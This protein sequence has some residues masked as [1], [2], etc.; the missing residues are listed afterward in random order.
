MNFFKRLY[1]ALV[2][3]KHT[4]VAEL[5]SVY[6][7]Y[8][9]NRFTQNKK[10]EY[11]NYPEEE[12]LDEKLWRYNFSCTGYNFALVPIAI[13]TVIDKIYPH[14]NDD[15]RAYVDRHYLYDYK[16]TND[17]TVFF[18]DE[19]VFNNVEKEFERLK[20]NHSK[21]LYTEE[22]AQNNFDILYSKIYNPENTEYIKIIP[23]EDKIDELIMTLIKYYNNSGY[24]LNDKIF[25]QT[26]FI[27]DEN[28]TSFLIFADSDAMAAE[29]SFLILTNHLAEIVE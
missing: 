3:I 21:V 13:K 6:Y 27:P 8:I 26:L 29:L 24:K 28:K 7:Y 10:N 11:V 9:G 15:T 19:D 18:K 16:N 23:N 17:V 5:G 25:N 12:K 14:D 2:N 4:A 20:N 22:T 1:Y